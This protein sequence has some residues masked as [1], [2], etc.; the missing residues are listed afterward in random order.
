MSIK[1]LYSV[2]DQKA[3]VYGT[4]FSCIN[5]SIAL[6]SFAH[7]ANDL[8][9]DIGVYPVDFTLYELGTFDEDTGILQPV[10]APR[11]IVCALQLV[12]PKGEVNEKSS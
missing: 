12:Q 1:T 11:P 7:A 5:E 6:R 9:T 4:P 10:P 2:F 8:G 3:Q